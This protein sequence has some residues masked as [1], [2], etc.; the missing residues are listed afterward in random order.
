MEEQ[1]KK[2]EELFGNE[3]KDVFFFL[4]MDKYRFYVDYICF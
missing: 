1:E 2:E 3:R 4:T